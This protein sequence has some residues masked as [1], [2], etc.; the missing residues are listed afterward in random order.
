MAS[1]IEETD[2]SG[3]P[4]AEAFAALGDE[5][6]MEIL[7]VLG[8]ADDSLSFSSLYERVGVGDSGQFNYHL[9]KLTGHF[10]EN[11]DDGYRLRQAGERVVQAILSG[12]ITDDPILAPTVIDIP[13]PYCSASTVLGYQGGIARHYCIECQGTYGEGAVLPTPSEETAAVWGGTE[14]LGF[15]GGI[16]VPPAVI[17]GRTPIEVFEA[18]HVWL[19]LEF[20][21][22]G[23]GLCP[24]C[25]GPVERSV[26]SVCESHDLTERICPDCESRY[27][28]LYQINCSN[29]H[30]NPSGSL[31]SLVRVNHKVLAFLTAHGLDPLTDGL[32][33]NW[34]EELIDTDPLAARYTCTLADE[35]LTVTVDDSL[36]VV[37]VTSSSST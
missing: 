13:C 24:R 10:V 23:R 17:Q 3:V 36:T 9:K 11:T 7:R 30:Y 19:E 1:D 31:V 35:T 15:L 20:F 33:V 29:C 16:S 21:A 27:A 12:A 22:V 4:P 32:E 6:R 26:R 8:K 34:N 5:I 25:S 28:V 2:L 37:D 18:V 14:E